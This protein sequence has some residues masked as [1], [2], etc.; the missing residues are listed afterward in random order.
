MI[1]GSD[2][3]IQT[4]AGKCALEYCIRA[5]MQSW[6]QAVFEDGETGRHFDSFWDLPIGDLTEVFVYRDK[7]AADHWDA[8][9]AIPGLEETMIHL[10]HQDGS[11]TIVVDDPDSSDT[12]RLLATIAKGLRTDLFSVTADVSEAA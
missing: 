4:G 12:S 7:V 6:P 5:A 10:I 3:H 8:E 11:I 2:I 9:G 1:G